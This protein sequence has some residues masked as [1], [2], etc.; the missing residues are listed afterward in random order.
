MSFTDTPFLV[1]VPLVFILWRLCGNNH[2]ARLLVLLAG[3]LIFYGY[4]EK[5]LLL[6]LLAYCVVNWS[7]GRSIEHWRRRLPAA[8]TALGV[9]VAFNLVVLGYW[10]YTPLL[11]STCARVAFALHLPA[12][13]V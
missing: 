13:P 5:W 12:V 11:L 7:V 6:L 8:R 4:H 2:R 9:G 3:S 1:L 10:K